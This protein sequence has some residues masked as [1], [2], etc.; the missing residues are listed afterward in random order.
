MGE[1]PSIAVGTMLVGGALQLLGSA[2]YI[3]T[4]YGSITALIPAFVGVPL[5]FC[6][7]AMAKTE[8]TKV[9]LHTHRPSL[10]ATRSPHN[11]CAVRKQ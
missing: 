5:L 10:P 3:S 1:S 7:L 11:C 9:Y 2:F 4:D 8:N 6:G